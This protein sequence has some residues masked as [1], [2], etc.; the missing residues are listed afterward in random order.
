M[1]TR[2]MKWLAVAALVWLLVALWRSSA[3]YT[4]ILAALAVWAAAIVV[5]VQ[6]IRASSY[7]W[8]ATFL[9]VVVFFNPIWPVMLARS[10]F[11][12]LDAA[13]IVVFVTS[14]FLLRAQPR[15]SLPSVT[16][17]T[18]RSEAL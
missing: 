5:L 3:N 13:C 10:M 6:A 7:V 18:A 1:L 11:R 4:T 15:L 17:L 16:E 12:W 14:L 9:G 8:A 2:T